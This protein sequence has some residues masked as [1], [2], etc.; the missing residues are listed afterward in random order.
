MRDKL[1]SKEKADKVYNLLVSIG[2]AF[3]K[4]RKDFIYHHCESVY[5]CSEWRFQ[6]KLGFGGK[7]YS[8][9]NRVCFYSEDET[10]ERNEIRSKLNDELLKIE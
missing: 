7:Y 1:I 5:G 2:G 9:N 4:R 8:R 10:P 3:E 6:G